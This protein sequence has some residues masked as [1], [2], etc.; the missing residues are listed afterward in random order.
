M[1]S[2]LTGISDLLK[3][4]YFDDKKTEPVTPFEQLICVMPP[5]SS[6]LL[7]KPYEYLMRSPHSPLKCK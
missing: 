2:D 7:P 1:L 5:S 6:Y 4:I 3:G